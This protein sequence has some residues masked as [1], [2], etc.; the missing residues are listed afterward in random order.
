M[1]QSVKM[2]SY[3]KE[4]QNSK[5]ERS[6][7]YS[8]I[9]TGQTFRVA[10]KDFM[11]ESKKKGDRKEGDR[12]PLDNDVFPSDIDIIPQYSVVEIMLNPSHTNSTNGMLSKFLYFLLYKPCTISY[13]SH[14]RWICIQRFKDSSM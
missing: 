3:T 4:G 6:E 11:Y 2:Y 10:L 9:T 14:D 7:T 1:Q 5:G 12:K 13:Y 8:T